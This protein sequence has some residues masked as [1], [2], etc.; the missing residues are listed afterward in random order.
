MTTGFP[1]RSRR[2]PVPIAV[3]VPIVSVSHAS[4]VSIPVTV[5]P[6]MFTVEPTVSEQLVKTQFTVSPDAT[7]KVAVEVLVTP[8]SSNL[9]SHSWATCRWRIRPRR[10]GT[11]FSPI[12]SWLVVGE[13]LTI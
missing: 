5:S 13:Q 7:W 12:V 9:R 4:K 1:A 2:S 6:E 8:V 11:H 3:V 10:V